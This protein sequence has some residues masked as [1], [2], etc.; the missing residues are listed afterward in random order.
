MDFIVIDDDRT[1]RDAICCLIDSEG[2]YAESACSGS[3]GLARIRTEK[4]SGVLLDLKLGGDNGL[5]ILQQI[6]ASHPHL[7]VVILTAEG[8]VKTAVEAMRCGA[9]DF[10]EKP[11]SREQFHLVLARVQRFQKM[12]QSI[13]L[14][15]QKVNEYRSNNPEPIFDFSTPEMLEVM[16]VISRAAKT[17]ASILIV[18]ETGTG[19]SMLAKAA[20]QQSRL[21]D[22]PFVTLSCPTL[23][24]E[25]LQ[26]ELF[27]HVKGSFTGAVRDHWGKIKT[28]D[29]GTLFLDEIGDL[30]IEIQPKLLRLLQEREYE[31]L[32]ENVT[33]KANVRVIAATNR[34][35][36]KR[37]AEGAFREDLYFRLNVIT[38]EMP[39]LR[40]RPADL[41]HFAKHYLKYFTKECGSNSRDF[42][43]DAIACLQAYAWPGNLRELRNVIERAAIMAKGDTIVPKDF[44]GELS[45]HTGTTIPCEHNSMLSLA[46]LE[47]R[48]VRDVLKRTSSLAEAA[49]FLGID[50][51]TLYRKRQ[52][53]GLL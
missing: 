42:S 53:I 5:D 37:I 9:V 52:K 32:G 44:P 16:D 11:F 48:H 28:A 29:G 24:K 39:P 8:N 12:S 19:K 3:M 36:K 34:D 17:S 51:A 25:L 47:E 4:F 15:E 6:Q 2:H 33:S 45:I 21:S 35:L 38:A 49:A 40:A 14:L 46:T 41:L 13:E 7:P 20:H 18:G 26:S 10:L 43:E 1:F 50:Q 27:G 22:R 30:P 31:R 23:S